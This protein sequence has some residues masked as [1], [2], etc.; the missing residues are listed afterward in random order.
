[1][2]EC[3]GGY[4][5]NFVTEV[6]DLLKCAVCQFVLKNPVI[7]VECGHRLCKECFENT[8]DYAILRGFDLL[9]P[10]DR[11]LIDKE[12]VYPDKG[13]ERRI[14]DLQVKCDNFDKGCAWR[15]ELRQLQEHVNMECPFETITCHHDG[16]DERIM[17]GALPPHEEKCPM[18]E[19]NQTRRMKHL[20]ITVVQIMERLKVC[21]NQ[22]KLYDQEKKDMSM[23]IK[24]KDEQLDILTA[25][26]KEK[27]L[28]L[29]ET[30]ENL[31]KNEDALDKIKKNMEKVSSK[32]SSNAERISAIGKDVQDNKRVEKIEKILDNH[33]KALD[34]V[35]TNFADVKICTIEKE[36]AANEKIIRY[37]KPFEETLI[38]SNALIDGLKSE[39]KSIRILQETILV[40]YFEWHITNYHEIW[41]KDYRDYRESL[42]FS[43]LNGYSC[44]LSAVW[45]YEEVE[46]VG[47]YFHILLGERDCDLV[48]PFNLKVTFE[49]C[50]VDNVKHKMSLQLDQSDVSWRKKPTEESQGRGFGFFNF[51][52][53]PDLDK[54]IIDD[55][56]TIKCYR[57]TM[58]NN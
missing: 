16:C 10:L 38:K 3:N 49:C 34:E 54:C 20:E 27:D 51:L 57:E 21:E 40:G 44:Y 17:R 7:I 2:A 14:L 39:M 46:A 24:S 31:Q 41:L 29:K 30:E 13:I 58:H 56:I 43:T 9:C 28:Q 8:K 6:H 18:K 11:N 42:P 12:K 47:I 45:Q 19:F 32:V 55:S 36:T 26:M 35:K 50:S 48:W 25:N 33:D 1:M 37:C 15:N 4:D 53:K 22:L 52:L 23:L 5:A